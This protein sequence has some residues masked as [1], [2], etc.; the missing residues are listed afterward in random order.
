MFNTPDCGWCH[1]ELGKFK[2]SAS[3]LTDVPYDVLDALIKHFEHGDI[4]GVYFDEEGSDFI[5]VIDRLY[6]YIIATRETD[7]LYKIDIYNDELAKEII[8]DIENNINGWAD[9]LS[10][11]DELNVDDRKSKLQE[12]I[13]KLKE[14]LEGK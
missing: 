7:K 8:S 4:M 1:V 3:Y 13:E 5:L 11:D 6:S 12:M 9:W 10:Y 14:L 2:G